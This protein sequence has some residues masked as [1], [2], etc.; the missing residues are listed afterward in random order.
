MCEAFEAYLSLVMHPVISFEHAMLLLTSIA[1]SKILALTT[2]DDCGA[3]WV[4][5]RFAD[6]QSFGVPQSFCTYCRSSAFPAETPNT[7]KRTIQTHHLSGYPIQ[8]QLFD[9]PRPDYRAQ[10]RE[11]PAALLAA[12]R[13]PSPHRT[14]APDGSQAPAANRTPTP[15]GAQAPAANRAPAPERTSSPKATPEPEAGPGGEGYR[16]DDAPP[17]G[18]DPDDAKGRTS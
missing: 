12:T 2:C 3:L 8:L 1:C 6:P 7:H 15:N 13:D 14:P 5:D 4:C 10:A 18:T 16:S 17:S 11:K 9:L